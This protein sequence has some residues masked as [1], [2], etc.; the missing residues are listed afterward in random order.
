M[1]YEQVV[2][3]AWRILP[4]L[5]ELLPPGQAEAT[6]EKLVELLERSEE[7]EPG[8]DD[9]I[10]ELLAEFDASRVW[11]QTAI[12]PPRRVERSGQFKVKKQQAEYVRVKIL[13][14]TDRRPTGKNEPD[15]FY[16]GVRADDEKLSFG[17]CEVSIPKSHSRGYVETPA[18]HKFQFKPD[19]HRH[20]V[21]LSVRPVGGDEFF[22]DVSGWVEQSE[23]KDT[24]VFLHGYR[25]TFEDAARR[26][27]QLAY[28]LPFR[29]APIL[30]SWPS[31]G[32]ILSYNRDEQEVEWTVPHLKQFLI[33]VAAR[34]GAKQIHLIAHS[35]GNRALTAALKEMSLEG[36]KPANFHHV[37]LTAPDID[38]GVFKQLASQVAGAAARVTLYASK[39]DTALWFSQRFHGYARA[40][41]VGDGL[42][43][44]PY[45][46]TVDASAVDTS[47]LGHSYFG[48]NRTVLSDIYSLLLGLLPAK[49]PDLE[50][51]TAKV[52]NYWRFRR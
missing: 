22:R 18:W 38:A 48:N 36:R 16:A 31:R 5:Q 32:R 24:F 45:L 33:D 50:A 3:A 20:V 51:V 44:L 39:K 15:N 25:V 27:A 9:Q 35:M 41:D 43:V 34:T 37:V 6:A 1:T 29:G 52:G 46:D 13:Y 40:G 8:V 30:Y 11:M 26:T 28:D 19:P 21:L 49:R 42:V 23:A 7:R 14:A 12:A 4:L 47:F 2:E 10:L 17:T